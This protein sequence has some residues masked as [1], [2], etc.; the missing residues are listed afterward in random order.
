VLERFARCAWL[1]V[2][3]RTGRTHQIRVHLA[4]LGHP[5]VADPT[6]G[7]LPPPFTSAQAGLP[8]PAR[9]LL[10][11]CALHAARLTFRHPL[12]GERVGFEAPLPADLR[13]AQEAL[14]SAGPAE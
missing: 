12:S 1:E 9:E 10:A 8:G 11:R 2:R 14:R 7:R 3:P 13:A 6:Y 4:H 5:I